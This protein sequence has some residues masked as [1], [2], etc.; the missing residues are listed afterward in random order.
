MYNF[1]SENDFFYN[2]NHTRAAKIF[3]LIEIF[4][5]TLKVNGDIDLE[6]LTKVMLYNF[7]Q[8]MNKKSNQ[9]IKN[10][11]ASIRAVLNSRIRESENL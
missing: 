6:A 3:F 5:N 1:N 8:S 4:K 7:A 2:I 11:M 10:Y 9:T